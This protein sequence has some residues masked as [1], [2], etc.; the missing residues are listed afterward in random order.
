MAGEQAVNMQHYSSYSDADLQAELLL[1]K[2]S[3]FFTSVDYS[4]HP[5]MALLNYV[6]GDA[7][8]GT[9]GWCWRG[10]YCG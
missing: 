6:L 4:Y 2:D 9:F 10:D 1:L 5:C 3:I 7:A 8:K